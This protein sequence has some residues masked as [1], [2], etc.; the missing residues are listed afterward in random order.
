MDLMMPGI[1]RSLANFDGGSRIFQTDHR[2][3]DGLILTFQWGIHFPIPNQTGMMFTVKLRADTPSTNRREDREPILWTR[4]DTITTIA[5][6]CGIRTH[7][8]TLPPTGRIRNTAHLYRHQHTQLIKGMGR[9][10]GHML[11]HIGRTGLKATTRGLHRLQ[12]RCISKKLRQWHL[13][14]CQHLVA[15]SRGRQGP[16]R[17]HS[18]IISPKGATRLPVITNR[19]TDPGKLFKGTT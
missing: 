5:W 18:R 15:N 10:A 16:H 11:Q 1:L 17:P 14:R 13:P 12:Y 2:D 3:R 9:A 8:T 7:V 19:H 6:V 4:V